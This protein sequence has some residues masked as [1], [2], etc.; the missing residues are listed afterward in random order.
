MD[1]PPVLQPLPAVL[2]GRRAFQ[3]LARGLCLR[4]WQVGLLVPSSRESPYNF[5]N[6]EGRGQD[7]DRKDPLLEAARADLHTQFQEFH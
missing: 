2:R 4:Q 5:F 3:S 1:S 7:G 6:A